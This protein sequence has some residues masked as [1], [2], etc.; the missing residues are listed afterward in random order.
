MDLDRA[1]VSRNN[2]ARAVWKLAI[3][4][5]L[6]LAGAG[7][8]WG[9]DDP[10]Y[11][12]FTRRN[13]QKF[14]AV[15]VRDLGK[16]YEVAVPGKE[17]TI[18]VT[19][20][21]ATRNGRNSPLQARLNGLL[22]GIDRWIRNGR[23]FN[24]KAD[25][26]KLK[27]AIEDYD[28]WVAP[29]LLTS[30]NSDECKAAIRNAKAYYRKE[31]AAVEPTIETF[32]ISKE[33]EGVLREI[34][35]GRRKPT[36]DLLLTLAGYHRQLTGV[37]NPSRL[38]EVERKRTFEELRQRTDKCLGALSAKVI[39]DYKKTLDLQ[40]TRGLLETLGKCADTDREYA[41]EQSR[42]IEAT[43]KTTA[44][45]AAKLPQIARDMFRFDGEVRLN[46]EDFRTHARKLR[47]INVSLDDM[48]RLAFGEDKEALAKSLKTR[49][50]ENETLIKKGE[51][52]R[53]RIQQIR[54]DFTKARR[55]ALDRKYRAA[56][57]AYRQLDDSLKGTELQ[58]RELREHIAR[59]IVKVRGSGLMQFLRNIDE[60]PV[61]ELPA[62]LQQAK[63]YRT[64]N[65]GKLDRD[66]L[67]DLSTKI[68]E[69]ESYV[70]FRDRLAVLD[71]QFKAD[72]K[73]TW[74]RMLDMEN[75]L[76]TERTLPP[77]AKQDWDTFTA[78][79]R[80]A[81]LE[82]V[83]KVARQED[84]LNLQSE[85]DRRILLTS[86]KFLLDGEQNE[87]AADLA[88]DA[89]TRVEGDYEHPLLSKLISLAIRA[90]NQMTAGGSMAKATRVFDQ[91]KERFPAYAEKPE[92]SRQL[93]NLLQIQAASLEKQNQPAAAL[94]AYSRIIE[95]F[96]KFA[97]LDVFNAYLRLKRQLD[98][99]LATDEAWFTFLE[100]FSKTF[101]AR[102][103]ETTAFTEFAATVQAQFA[104]TWEADTE[105]AA[106]REFAAAYEK[107]PTVFKE[108]GAIEEILKTTHAKLEPKF[109]EQEQRA[110][111]NRIVECLEILIRPEFKDLVEEQDL[112]R[113]LVEFKLRQANML[114]ELNQVGSIERAY[115][116]LEEISR[117]F[118]SLAR[119]H[120]VSELMQ[121][122]LWKRRLDQF[123]RPLGI[124][125]Y[126]DWIALGTWILFWLAYFLRAVRMGKKFGHL[127]YSISHFFT[128]FISFLIL[129]AVFLVGGQGTYR[130][131]Y[132][133]GL[134]LAIPTIIFA[135]LG[136]FNG[137]GLF[138]YVFFPLIYARRRLN[139]SRVLL[140]AGG[141]LPGLKERLAPLKEHV[142]AME[143][144][145][146]LLHD[147]WLFRIVQASR[148]AE[149]DPE[150]SYHTFQ[151]LY[152]KLDKELR[153]DETWKEHRLNCIFNM[154]QLAWSL[155]RSEEAEA[156]LK[157]HLEHEPRA[158]DTHEVLADLYYTNE[159][160]EEAVNHLKICLGAQ[161]QNDALWY[162][163]GRSF[164]ETGKYKAAFKCFETMKHQ[165]RDSLFY[166][167]RAF[168]NAG[169][170]QRSV[171]WYQKLL[172][173]NPEDGEAVYYLASSF[174]QLNEDV[175]A[176]KIINLVKPENEFYPQALA[177]QGSLLFR[178]KKLEKAQEFF[179]AALQY[180]VALPQALLGQ[181]QLALEQGNLDEAQQLLASLVKRVPKTAPG[182]YFY[183]V[184][185]E[186]NGQPDQAL[187]HF[188]KALDNDTFRRQAANHIGRVHFFA[189]RYPEAVKAFETADAAGERSAWFYFLYA[190]ALVQME[191]I[192]RSEGVIVKILG[193]TAPDAEWQALSA[194]AMYT[195]GF[196]LFE[197]G[198]F[199]MA[200]Q[201]FEYVKQHAPELQERLDDLIEEARF[202]TVVS[203][204]EAGDYD[205]SMD[206]IS[207][208]QLSTQ[209]KT[210]FT[211]CQYYTALCHLFRAEFAPAKAVLENLFAQDPDNVRYLY[212]MA[213]AEL[214]TGE[215]ER[216]RGMMDKLSAE[217]DVPPHIKVGLGT[218][219]AFLMAEDGKEREAEQ[220]LADI[221]EARA[222]FPGHMHVQQ[223]LLGTRAYYL[224]RIQDSAR[225][226]FLIHEM[227]PA[228]QAK[229]AY[230][231]A[232][233]CLEGGHLSAAVN[234][235]QPFA[236]ETEEA[237]RLYTTLAAELAAT[238]VKDGNE[239]R[240]TE[241]LESIP[242]PPEAIVSALEAL[243]M[244][245]ILGNTD[246]IEGLSEAVAALQKSLT[247]SNDP[248]LVHS[249][250]HNLS[251]LVLR[252]AML[253]EGTRDKENVEE[254][255]QNFWTF[256]DTHV[257]GN[258]AYWSQ[259]RARLET[260]GEPQP[261]SPDEVATLN[262]AVREETLMKIFMG[263]IF[264]YLKETGGHTDMM[265]HL[266]YF[267]TLGKQDDKLSEYM[268]RLGRDAKVFVDGI[269]KN[270]PVLKT[271]DFVISYMR[272]QVAVAEITRIDDLPTLHEQLDTY[273]EFR[274]HYAAPSDY[275]QAKK[276]FNTELLDTLQEGINGKFSPAGIRLEKILSEI[277]HGVNIGPIEEAL[278]NLRDACRKPSA[279]F[280]RGINLV[281]EF[282]R[283]Y[284]R[285]VNF[286]LQKG[287]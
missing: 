70:T 205:S 51:A 269:E 236:S 264:A 207:E 125:D 24:A 250:I 286:S 167:A 227:A 94:A 187:D 181:G 209:D 176:F 134:A 114:V 239:K 44:A 18:V 74:S 96:P 103:A 23:F 238:A 102:L 230:M 150:K 29:K 146:P 32:K 127:R 15:V 268:K 104:A 12:S 219:Q 92:F 69:L 110:V 107:Y 255:W 21:E 172:K 283:M 276:V 144:D 91:I 72:P 215:V 158:L 244:A 117:D 192:E 95:E 82:Q 88:A 193:H 76:A 226:Q 36:T 180:D 62:L 1:G 242:D 8:V 130:H 97:E 41:R 278:W 126:I 237:V 141:W 178:N 174:A 31:Y 143:A 85:P 4:F 257:F 183:G 136:L 137:F 213:V 284:Q 168:A 272:I 54:S 245:K 147:R 259:C 221:P 265:R 46:Q 39:A 53:D 28:K 20:L 132:S 75:Y 260:G 175:K 196:Q 151:R 86:L 246:T 142:D 35:L 99:E 273:L 101:G 135:F 93:I 48:A 98:A 155:G 248:S 37:E 131:V 115:G 240:A 66:V 217:S 214:G 277:P 87:A 59:R 200:A 208:L 61:D 262:A 11:E 198:D 89:W 128:V 47:Q 78:G 119:E 65:R 56:I 258:E 121:K 60:L 280:D 84:G 243:H 90:A 34:D 206:L 218:M 42:I 133:A 173:T 80:A 22:N 67:A 105:L 166:G 224:C 159:R 188:A 234:N 223:K 113:M 160:Y 232:L 266:N 68:A 153:K 233:S 6:S 17:G 287:N 179:Q 33:I 77:A 7:S 71:K 109:K 19:R 216:A 45:F 122:W 211:A 191:E 202:R 285:V 263:Y 165:D 55:L 118:P 9:R 169:M 16:A 145:L 201:C 5:G 124:Y 149:E 163:L 194:K 100:E 281:T 197:H 13:G 50:T 49:K 190:Y 222:E 256:W 112:H 38:A 252:L 111:S 254:F 270:D 189:Q 57:E 116:I 275:M 282:E 25:L 164:F 185:L 251:V 225:L 235:L 182:N 177:L 83:V 64:K 152:Q 26:P 108:S 139:Y 30:T 138:P 261:F 27:Q 271:W 279:A 161:G 63:A 203:L 204:L 228:T 129:L 10:L 210:R 229:A 52:I 184:V 195:L 162:R 73:R 81:A 247:L 58:V 249:I 140:K 157:E 170:H 267:T 231:Q 43:I 3:A 171:E 274:N 156:Y 186:K 212:H 14:N 106:A 123:R 154:G 241:I 148:I 220:L 40:L 2:W 253:V 79:H 199:K 120:E